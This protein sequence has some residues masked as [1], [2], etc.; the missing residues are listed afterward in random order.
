M[1]K[2]ELD[3]IRMLPV[4][5]IVLAVFIAFNVSVFATEDEALQPQGDI[6]SVETETVIEELTIKPSNLADPDTLLEQYIEEA[7]PVLVEDA[8]MGQADSSGDNNEDFPIRSARFWKLGENE[9]SAYLKIREMLRS[10][11]SGNQSE[12]SIKLSYA[13]VFSE[14][15]LNARYTADDLLVDS[16]VEYDEETGKY[17]IYNAVDA[18]KTK[19]PLD[20]DKTIKALLADYPELLF[21]YDKT[22]GVSIGFG[23]QPCINED[24]TEIWFDIDDS[25]Y[26]LEFTVSGDYTAEDQTGDYTV[27]SGK[28]GKVETAIRNAAAIIESAKGR[29]DYFKLLFYKNRICNLV[30]YNDDVAEDEDYPYGD[31]WQ[32]VYVFDG[33]NNTNVVCEGYSKA[34]KY[35]CDWS[36]FNEENFSCVVVT[37]LTRLDSEEIPTKH[38]WNVVGFDGGHYLVDATNCDEGSVG[39]ENYLFLRG[40]EEES[41][42]GYTMDLPG[43]SSLEYSYDDSTKSM[44]DPNELTLAKADY[45]SEFKEVE[46]PIGKRLSYNGGSQFGVDNDEGYTLYG[47]TYATVV[48]SYVAYAKLNN[49]YIWSDGTT[50]QK[51]IRWS[52]KT[53]SEKIS[54]PLGRTYE[55]DGKSKVGVNP[56]KYYSLSGTTSE[57]KPGTY[58][59]KATLCQPDNKNIRYAWSD[60]S[61]TAKTIKWSILVVV[62]IPAGKTFTYDGKS[63]NGVDTGDDY[64]ISGT[65][66]ATNAGSYKVTAKLKSTAGYIWSDG[67]TEQKTISWKINKRAIGKTDILGINA[68]TYTGNALMQSPTLKFGGKTLKN[69]TDYTL[70]YKNNK[71]VGRASVTISGCGNFNG[72]VTKTFNINPKGTSLKKLTPLAKGMTVYW[73]KQTAKMSTSTITGYQVQIATDANFKKNVKTYTVK[74]YKCES[75]K[76]TGLKAKTKY[77]VRICTYKTLKISGKDTNFYSGWSGAKNVVTKK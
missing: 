21:W 4:L 47:T 32:F 74:G 30:S 45:K 42:D 33:D 57:K 35:L 24:C 62:D 11:S 58:T 14:D 50:E 8:M 18:L 53:K 26:E 25:Y 51:T 34:F 37:G 39:Y 23:Y 29:N 59:V 28:I 5:G 65:K 52:I 46:V 66:S 17:G 68:K 71:N 13:D 2:K 77:Y 69:G 12:A 70:T 3:R 44:F 54:I 27:D 9:Q 6:D 16:I 31:P 61:S 48:G 63:H 10:V 73:N 55:Y 22:K 40:D 43:E 20:I 36:S 56:S 41:S 49:N 72:S 7:G 15:I 60:G 64:T 1:N 19:Y 75:K 67:T 38:M 76:I